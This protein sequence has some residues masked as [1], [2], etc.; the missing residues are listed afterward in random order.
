MSNLKQLKIRIQSVKSTQKITKAMK[1]VAASK[2]M[3]ARKKMEAAIPYVDKMQLM[4]NNL[5]TVTDKEEQISELLIGNGKDNRYLLIVVTSDKGLC[6]GFNSNVIRKLQ[7]VIEE[8]QKN[9]KRFKIFCLGKKGHDIL[10]YRYAKHIIGFHYG[11]SKDVI[12]FDYANKLAKQ[13]IEMFFNQEFDICQVISNH[14]KSPIL[15]EV[16]KKQLI[17]AEKVVNNDIMQKYE[18]EP[19]EEYILNELLPRNVVVQLLYIM[20]DSVASEHG[21]RMTAMEN[22]TNNAD[23]M[24]KKLTLKYN[25]SRQATITSELIEIISGAEALKG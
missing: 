23:D 10:K 12:D 11:L 19:N 5:V 3:R 1:M 21:G 22:A 14:F 24:I 2:L 18:Y 7:L 25:R 20:L 6:G 17:P 8:L 4:I 16:R 15:Q 13:F 9:D